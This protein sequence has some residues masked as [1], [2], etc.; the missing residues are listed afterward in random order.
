MLMTLCQSGAR[1]SRVRLLGARLF[2]TRL[3]RS[4]NQCVGR[5]VHLVIVAIVAVVISGCTSEVDAPPEE[6]IPKT[7]VTGLFPFEFSVTDLTGKTVSTESLKGKVVIVDFW[8]TWCPPC[9]Q[10]IPH[11]VALHQKYKS[12]GLEIVGLTFE[13]TSGDAALNGVTQFMRSARVSY[14]CALAG[15]DMLQK[16]PDFEGFPTT[17]FIDREGRVRARETGYRPYGELEQVV[18]T[19][20]AEAN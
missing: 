8:G 13:R 9:R 4:W 2:G 5:S 14:P 16:V 1:A 20:L 6:T 18:K 3:S 15:Q 7:T 17:L 11:F 12:Q 19:L 10:E